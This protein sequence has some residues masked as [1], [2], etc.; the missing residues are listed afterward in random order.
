M[1]PF[2][3]PATLQLFKMFNF[4]KEITVKFSKSL[5]FQG[6]CSEVSGDLFY[7]TPCIFVVDRLCTVFL[8]ESRIMLIIRSVIKSL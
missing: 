4:A 6:F 1:N 5:I 2:L 7:R 8:R 3:E